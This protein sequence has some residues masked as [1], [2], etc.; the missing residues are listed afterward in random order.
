MNISN[1]DRQTI[2]ELV[3]KTTKPMAKRARVWTVREKTGVLKGV[4]D[5]VWRTIL[6][7]TEVAGSGK[8][9]FVRCYFSSNQIRDQFLTEIQSVLHGGYL[10][11]Y[12]NGYQDQNGNYY[13]ND[14]TPVGKVLE[15]EKQ[16]LF[17][18]LSNTTLIIAGAF[19]VVI[20]LLL[21]RKKS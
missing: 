13:N 4:I 16:E 8:E 10:E 18:G 19:I 6:T 2:S 14:G 20:I 21:N 3:T 15:D 1:S 17:T 12:G 11:P 7:K 9:Q 5:R